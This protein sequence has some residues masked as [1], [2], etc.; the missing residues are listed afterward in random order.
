MELTEQQLEKRIQHDLGMVIDRNK[1]ILGNV[2]KTWIVAK[3]QSV[4][5]INAEELLL[6][7]CDERN[8]G[9][10]NVMRA[11]AYVANHM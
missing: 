2:I 4:E 9:R 5:E 7:A 6:T 8:I 10:E 1:N 11:I 3:D